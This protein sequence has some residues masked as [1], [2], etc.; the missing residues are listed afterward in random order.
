[1]FLFLHGLYTLQCIWKFCTIIAPMPLDVMQLSSLTLK[2]C[3]SLWCCYLLCLKGLGH[4]LQR[5]SSS[6][7]HFHCEHENLSFS[8]T[9]KKKTFPIELSLVKENLLGIIICLGTEEMAQ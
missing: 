1:M 7:L 8:E 6:A 3:S 5:V 9:T 4:F 2:L